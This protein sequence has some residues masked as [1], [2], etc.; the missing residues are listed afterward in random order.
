MLAMIAALS[1]IVLLC[2]L[3]QACGV[4]VCM[5]CYVH[6]MPPQQQCVGFV[7]NVKLVFL[8]VMSLMAVHMLQIAC[9]GFFFVL[10]GAF[11]DLYV[12]VYFSGAT[13]TT[14]GYGDVV[15]PRGRWLLGPLE[16]ITGLLMVGVSTAVMVA[17][18]TN[19]TTRLVT[20]LRERQQAQAE[21]M[22]ISS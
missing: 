5:R 12:A 6:F 8:M 15:L 21:K 18:V 7:G 2:V 11:D 1:A 9:W 22:V 13:F 17:V 4:V 14:I 10:I 3:I 16:G 19:M 20:Q